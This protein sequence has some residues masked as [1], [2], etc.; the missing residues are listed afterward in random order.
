MKPYLLRAIL[1]LL[2]IT[3][4]ASAES[5]QIRGVSSGGS[6]C[7]QG[8]VQL[9]PDNKGF[10]LVPHEFLAAIGPETARKENRKFC[11]ISVDLQVPPGWSY[12]AEVQWQGDATLD[13]EINGTA[14]I[15]TYFDSTNEIKVA[16][17][18]AGGFDGEWTMSNDSDLLWSKCD[19]TASLN[20]KTELRLSGTDRNASG[21][22]ELRVQSVQFK[23]R[24]CES[25]A[26][27]YENHL[28]DQGGKNNW[29][30]AQISPSHD[31]G[32]VWTN[33]AGVSWV[34]AA[35][36]NPNE[37]AIGVD[38]PY[39]YAGYHMA[40]VERGNNGQVT[41]IFGPYSEPYDRHH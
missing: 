10:S 12:A 35:T 24:P 34:L 18:L 31:G 39:Y 30:Y 11:Q 4:L 36:A 1:P 33:R 14:S 15:L 21:L 3:S 23:V 22:A 26:G 16:R 25:M 9:D 38:C 27:L 2:V 40:R 8:N 13:L 6:G 19:E 32:Y 5:I 28:Y 7:P 29:H 41:R 17:Q 20:I 37:Y